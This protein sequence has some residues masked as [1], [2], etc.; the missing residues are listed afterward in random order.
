VVCTPASPIDRKLD[1][2]ITNRTMRERRPMTVTDEIVIPAGA[3]SVTKVIPFPSST[4]NYVISLNV[5]EDGAFYEDL[6]F[7]NG[8]MFV[9]GMGRGSIPS[10]LFVT[11]K[12][13]DVGR[14][15]FVTDSMAYMNNFSVPF[16]APPGATPAVASRSTTNGAP[17]VPTVSVGQIGPFASMPAGELFDDWINYSALDVIFISASDVESLAANRPKVLK[18]LRD[19]TM[20]GGNLCVF[21][22]GKEW[23]GLSPF[24]ERLD[25]VPDP[26]D[27]A[28]PRRGW[29]AA[30]PSYYNFPLQ[31]PGGAVVVRQD[32]DVD[33]TG[34]RNAKKSKAPKEVPFVWKPAGMGLVVGIADADPFPGDTLT[35]RWLFNTIEP[36]RW[37]WEARHGVS[38]TDGNTSFDDYA[39]PDV[40]LPPVRTYRVLITLFVVGIGPVNYWLLRRKGRLHLLL[41]TVPVA[42]MLISLG[43]LAYAVI[44]DGFETYFL[45][46]SFTQLDQRRREAVSWSRLSYY[47]GVAPAGGMQFGRDTAVLPIERD[48]YYRRSYAMRQVDWTNE[49]NLVRGWLNSR[50]PVQYLT[51]RP[52]ACKR[53]LRVFESAA[54][55]GCAVD[56][57]LDTNVKFLMLRTVGNK[58]YFGRDIKAGTRVELQALDSDSKAQQA[59]LDMLGERSRVANAVAGNSATPASR[60]FFA[61]NPNYRYQRNAGSYYYNHSSL[62]TSALDNAFSEIGAHLAQP[63]TYIAIVDRPADVSAG[64]DGLSERPSLHV[65]RGTW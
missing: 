62:L 8:S 34:S 12:Q 48:S 64:T 56:N 30:D 57:R 6:S 39:I 47:A 1:I 53:E 5:W 43:L 28:K 31:Q 20:A 45:S 14:F 22:M 11:D 44:A 27:A 49:Q 9:V 7:E 41:F 51:V 33:A 10:I 54:Q 2:E 40:G 55:D 29:S 38:I 46:Q 61:P 58:L 59:A 18:A 16:N 15:D 3:I 50:T 24:E 25:W 52:Y 19:W 26:A 65:I 42:A 63:G 17:V 23:E 36:S 13:I 21:G 37:Q 60:A 4:N 35:W 32:S